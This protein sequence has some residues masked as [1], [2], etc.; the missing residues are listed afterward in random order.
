MIL[1]SCTFVVPSNAL[2]ENI[3]GGIHKAVKGATKSAA[4]NRVTCLEFKDAMASK[5]INPAAGLHQK[6][7]N[8]RKSFCAGACG[9]TSCKTKEVFSVCKKVCAPAE[10]PNCGRTGT[11]AKAKRHSQREM[12]EEEQQEE[13]QE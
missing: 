4:C 9:A 7:A 8:C 11:K 3:T 5:C 12:Q 13:H 10:I 1:F 6:Q 2:F